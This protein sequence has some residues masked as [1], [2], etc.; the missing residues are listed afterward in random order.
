MN[1][2]QAKELVTEIEEIQSLMI[3]Y[4]TDGRADDQPS[5]YRTV[6]DDVLFELEDAGY[7]NPNPHKTLEIFWSYC[8][9]Q[10]MGTWAE[11][12]AYVRELYADISIELKRIQRDLPDPRNWKKAN[13]EL[14]DELSPVR[15]QWLKAKNFIF[16]Q[17][18][19]YENS[20]KEAINSV[21]S[22]LMILLNQPNGTLGKLIKK[23]DLDP[24]ISK[25]ISQAYGLTSNKDFVR[26]G[27]VEDQMIGKTEAEFFLEFAAVSIIYIR[28]K[29][30][31]TKEP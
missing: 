27:G 3:A 23:A 24:D 20:I 9:L 6:Y 5:Q 8:K 26:H 31:G 29:L 4:V 12:R 13:E 14:T 17:A 15:T 1:K 7:E 11:R 30:K 18:P 19:D 16:A 28:E 25:I 10:E 21:E 22:T 2:K